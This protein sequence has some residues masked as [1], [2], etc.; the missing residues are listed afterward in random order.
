MTKTDFLESTYE[1]INENEK[2][3][4]F[5]RIP[6]SGNNRHYFFIESKNQLDK[7]VQKSNESDSI[8]IFKNI[9]EYDSG[10]ITTEF[11][12]KNIVLSSKEVFKLELVIITD[13]YD[14]YEKKG[15]SEW[16]YIENLT[17]L[18]SILL[19]NIGKIAVII[20]EPNF[21]NEQNTY[22][23]YVPNKNGISKPGIAY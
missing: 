10:L 8:T 5:V 20:L 22:H 2:V 4:A 7:L 19:D 16:E 13:T 9:T 6:N 15:Y 3:L 14:E 21:C 1:L 12:N 18:K 17:D 23:L 11:I